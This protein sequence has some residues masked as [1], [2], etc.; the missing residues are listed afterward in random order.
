MAVC[1]TYAIHD[2]EERF[3]NG[4]QNHTLATDSNPYELSQCVVLCN[5]PWC[6]LLLCSAGFGSRDNLRFGWISVSGQPT[7][8]FVCERF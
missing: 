7:L 2:N 8:F 1:F 4:V 6:R 3:L 5:Y